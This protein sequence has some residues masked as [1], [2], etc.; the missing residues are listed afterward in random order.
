VSLVL[1]VEDEPAVREA[2]VE[3]LSLEGYEVATAG[4]GEEGLDKAR[5]G[6]PDVV[7][8]DWMLPGMSGL[9]VCQTLRTESSVPIIMVTAR[10][11][12]VDRVRGLELGADD[13]VVKPFSIAELVSRVR[14]LQR[15]QELERERA[16][17][18]HQESTLAAGPIAVDFTAM[19]VTVA[20][21]EVA[22]TTSEF[23]LL[24][25][26]ASE[27]GRVF[28]RQQIMENLW[29]SLYVGDARAADVHVKTLRRKLERDPARPALIVTVRG[30][31]YKLDV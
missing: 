31:G 13:Y 3:G 16:A 25:Q 26:L 24:V 23:K 18:D 9:D 30:V 11:Q 7:I 29:Q 21:A 5:T 22:L 17:N 12:E 19:R 2:I 20:G 14:A 27:P 10:G 1:V 15:R 28:T 6:N 4:N 8:L